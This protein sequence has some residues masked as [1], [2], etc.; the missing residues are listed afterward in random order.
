LGGRVRV[1]ALSF[2]VG[3]SKF[4]GPVYSSVALQSL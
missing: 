4:S 1:A 2:Q 3:R